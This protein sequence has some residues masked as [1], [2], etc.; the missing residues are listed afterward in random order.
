M[1]NYDAAKAVKIAD[2]RAAVVKAAKWAY[3]NGLAPPHL[4]RAVEAL[5]RQE[6]E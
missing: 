1:S 6:V 5:E 3:D 2:L 4:A